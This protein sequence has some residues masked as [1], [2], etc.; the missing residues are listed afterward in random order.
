MSSPET[1]EPKKNK[2]VL[3]QLSGRKVGDLTVEEYQEVVECTNADIYDKI[4]NLRKEIDEL[5]EVNEKITKEMLEWKE[6]TLLLERDL[7]QIDRRQKRSNIVLRGL[8]DSQAP[9]ATVEDLCSN[10]LKVDDVKVKDVRKTFQ[11]NGKMTVVA[12]LADADMVNSV[13][14][15]TVNLKGSSISI[16]RDLTRESREKKSVMMKLKKD[17]LEQDTSKKIIVRDDRLKV[18]NNWF[19]W[20]ADKQLK[21]GSLEGR[22]ALQNIYRNSEVINNL[23]LDYSKIFKKC[24]RQ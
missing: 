1:P 9:R 4:I 3:C 13:L 22:T 23:E 8:N 21:S 10:V 16:D 19:Y 6:K 18:D 12:E 15:S 2:N 5:K 17:L 20:N 11:K 14:K 24:I 7:T